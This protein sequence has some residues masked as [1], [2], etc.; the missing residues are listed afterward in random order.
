M[1]KKGALSI[2]EMILLMLFIVVALGN[3]FNIDFKTEYQGSQT[4]STVNQARTG[5]IGFWDN[6]LKTPVLYLWRSFIDNMQRIHDA[7]PT[8]FDLAAPSVPTIPYTPH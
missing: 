1:Y 4:E 7:Q 2:L 3:Y 8:D 6:H 5:L